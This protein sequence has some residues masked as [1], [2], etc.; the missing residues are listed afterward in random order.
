MK[1]IYLDGVVEP[2]TPSKAELLQAAENAQK[3][4]D[5]GDRGGAYLELYK[6][7]GN[8][9]MLMH[10]QITTYSGAPG[11]MAVNANF[12]AK[13]A[14]PEKYQITLD[15]FS[16]KI[17]QSI[18]DLAKHA[19]KTD[20][21]E[22]NNQNIWKADSKVWKELNMGELFPGNIQQILRN[23]DIASSR[24][25][26]HAF[27]SQDEAELGKRPA[28]YEGKPDLYSIHKSKD[29]RFTTVIDKQ[30]NRVE[31]V[32]DKK[33]DAT[34]G[35][36]VD[37][38]VYD[39]Q[40][41]QVNDKKPSDRVLAERHMKMTYLQAGEI[42]PES[43]L[44]KFDPNNPK[45]PKN[46][47]RVFE[48]KGKL[49]QFD[50]KAG[51]EADGVSFKNIIGGRAGF[52]DTFR[53]LG[54]GR[55]FINSL[56]KY[57]KQADLV[58][59]PKATDAERQRMFEKLSGK[60]VIKPLTKEQETY[61]RNAIDELK[62]RSDIPF[63]DRKSVSPYQKQSESTKELRDSLK[64]GKKGLF[65]ENENPDPYK[66]AAQAHESMHKM[67]KAMERDKVA[68]LDPSRN[69]PDLAVGL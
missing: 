30:T 20:P 65:S 27:L 26:L 53:R 32:F 6:V 52:R 56:T 66:V 22:F 43:E 49:Y 59:D 35:T 42:K 13:L 46:L 11:G 1:P 45:P 4:L 54:E 39:L 44:S 47:D 19:A 60:G 28:E 33:F 69:Q 31:V 50:F 55:D 12:L 21:K 63:K 9:L 67:G 29:G 5:A 68:A 40:V 17:D 16:H 62:Q 58:T 3:R 36:A 25:G 18:I 37:G 15:R 57:G 7:T 24:G 10:A 23:P 14:N 64:S 2:R 34:Y 41:A 51:V 8:P 38:K 61:Y 48:Y